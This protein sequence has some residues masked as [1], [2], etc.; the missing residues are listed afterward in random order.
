ML[1]VTRTLHPQDTAVGDLR[2]PNPSVLHSGDDF[3]WGF[4]NKQPLNLS[5][6]CWQPLCE[7]KTFCVLCVFSLVGW[8]PA[9]HI[10][11]CES[12]HKQGLEHESLYLREERQR[13]RVHTFGE[14]SVHDL[15]IL[16]W[17]WVQL[18]IQLL[19]NKYINVPW[20]YYLWI[21]SSSLKQ[22]EPWLK[23]LP[24]DSVPVVFIQFI[25]LQKTIFQKSK[26]I[27]QN[28]L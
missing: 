10:Q 6:G 21:L 7:T 28:N 18:H 19:N 4:T 3:H 12:G 9:P 16:T 15:D 2:S 11:L 25:W 27:L 1:P 5:S 22:S 23:D 26:C 8:R 24:S 20:R 13:A 14:H 17:Q